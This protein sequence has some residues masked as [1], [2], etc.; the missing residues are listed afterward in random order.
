MY[1]SMICHEGDAKGHKELQ[2][3]QLMLRNLEEF[4]DLPSPE[5]AKIQSEAFMERSCQDSVHSQ[6][7]FLKSNPSTDTQSL[8]V[9]LADSG[10]IPAARNESLNKS[11]LE[12][13]NDLSDVEEDIVL[14]EEDNW[15]VFAS[16]VL[17]KSPI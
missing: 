12:D 7:D 1:L 4:N 5:K 11:L 10:Y 9:L 14:D 3:L 16:G 13:L 2:K 15:Y 8:P 17:V 6:M